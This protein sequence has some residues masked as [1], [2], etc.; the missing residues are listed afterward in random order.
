MGRSHAGVPRSACA[1]VCHT[2]LTRLVQLG[3]LCM[4]ASIPE[5]A[6][7]LICQCAVDPC[8]TARR[9]RDCCEVCMISSVALCAC[10]CIAMCMLPEACL[11]RMSL[12][13]RRLVR[14]LC[15]ECQL[16]S[17][18]CALQQPRTQGIRKR[19][20]LLVAGT[21]SASSALPCQ[22][23]PQL[24]VA[25]ALMVCAERSPNSVHRTCSLF[26]LCLRGSATGIA[27]IVS[28]TCGILKALPCRLAHAKINNE[29][30]NVYKDT[31]LA[32]G[33]QK[34]GRTWMS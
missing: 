28:Q 33:I 27:R 29:N 13:M 19:Q 2:A 32:A 7:A 16:G 12:Q 26:R 18:C 24:A 1:A 23:Q 20:L 22:S 11:V 10:L 5:L 21:G 31:M 17:I 4:R 15:L 3:T 6:A 14:V 25:H 30:L 34:C 9:Q 8:C